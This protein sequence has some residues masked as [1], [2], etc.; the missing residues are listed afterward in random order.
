[1]RNSTRP[2]G[3]SLEVVKTFS[4][5]VEAERQYQLMT[6][7]STAL[8][9]RRLS[10]N[11]FSMPLVSQRIP[12]SAFV[13]VLRMF[14][15]LWQQPPL[16]WRVASRAQYADYV[17]Q[18]IGAIKDQQ[19]RP[20]LSAVFEK[21]YADAAGRPS[22]RAVFVHGDA[23]LSNCVYTEEGVRFIDFSPKASPPEEEVDLAKLLFSSY[24][25]DTDRDQG[26]ALRR[27]VSSTGAFRRASP[28]LITFYLVSHLARVASK[29]PAETLA[30]KRFYLEVLSNA[31][32]SVQ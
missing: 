28:A 16:A 5:A 15:L 30:R 1:M 21:A 6:A 8:P 10:D 19:L 13:D 14:E 3:A 32:F 2:S 22:D 12:P 29:E 7:T 23:T 11:Q 27:V 18:R 26:S 24:G 9:V 31:E 20:R 17:R 4:D 25:F